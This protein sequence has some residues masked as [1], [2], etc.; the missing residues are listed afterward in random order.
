MNFRFNEKSC[1]SNNNNKT[2][3]VFREIN[4][5]FM[6]TSDLHMHLHTHVH[7]HIHISRIYTQAHKGDRKP[8]AQQEHLRVAEERSKQIEGKGSGLKSWISALPTA[9]VSL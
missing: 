7:T 8:W 5:Y 9:G 3:I 6:L 4:R 1:L 2:I